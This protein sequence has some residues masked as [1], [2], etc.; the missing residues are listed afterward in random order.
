MLDVPFYTERL[1]NL[2]FMARFEEER[3]EAEPMLADIHKAAEIVRTNKCFHRMLETVLL[4][5]NYMNSSNNKKCALG[6]KLPFLAQLKNTKTVDNKGT[7][8]HFLAEL[9]IDN[10]ILATRFISMT[11]APLHTRLAHK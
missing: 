1:E 5:G 10:T 7:L 6:F 4:I 8:L 3:R 11:L 9:A 2:L